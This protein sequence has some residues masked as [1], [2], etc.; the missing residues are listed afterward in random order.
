MQMMG[1]L[2]YRRIHQHVV[3][4][5]VMVVDEYLVGVGLVEPVHFLAFFPGEHHGKIERGILDGEEQFLD[6]V[7][8]H[9]SGF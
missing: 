2:V 9:G 1:V 4:L 5:E 7:L 8:I 3:V 6:A